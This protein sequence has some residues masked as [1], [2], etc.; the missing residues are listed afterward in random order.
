MPAMQAVESRSHARR[1]LP[2]CRWSVPTSGG[3]SNIE[4][5]FQCRVAGINELYGRNHAEFGVFAHRPRVRGSAR[6]R[7]VLHVALRFFRRDLS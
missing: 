7:A 5:G 3:T 1:P 4:C 6:H 2:D